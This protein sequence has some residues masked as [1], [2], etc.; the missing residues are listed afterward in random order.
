MAID[1]HFQTAQVAYQDLL[2]LHRGEA[3]SELIGS[4]EERQ[5]NGRVYLCDK[6]RIGTEMKS[7]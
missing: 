2:R 5:R 6:F 4:V 7:L 1:S 3:A